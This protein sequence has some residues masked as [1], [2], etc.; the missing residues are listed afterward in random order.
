MP[1]EK[2]MRPQFI[3]GPAKIILYLRLI[4]DVWLHC[5]GLFLRGKVGGPIQYLKLLRNLLL[6]LKVV[7]ANKVVKIGDL[8]KL[9][10]YL[11]AWPSPAFYESIQKFIRPDPGPLTVV[12]SMTKACGYKCPHCYQRNDGGKDLDPEL[13]HKAA[14][15]MQKAGVTMFDIEGGEPLLRFERLL[16]LLEQFDGKR[17]IWVNTTGHTLDKDKAQKM[18]DAGVFGVMI[19]LH[20]PDPASY[21]EF[22]GVPG[23]FEYAREAARL[24]NEVGITVVINHCPSA[25]MLDDGGTV[26]VL[27]TA[28]EWGCSFVQVIHGKSAGAWLGRS[29]DIHLKEQYRKLEELHVSWNSDNE[30]KNKVAAS[31][32]VFEESEAH[33]GCTAGGIDRFYLNAHGEVQPCEFLNISFGNVQTDDFKTIFGRMRSYFRKPGTHWLCCTLA[34]PIHKLMKEKNLTET[35]LT[36]EHTKELLQNWEKGPETKL[37]KD[38]DLYN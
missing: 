5:T 26:K 14:R 20:T 4:L 6:L 13:L 29:E 35:P 31:V 36:W 19:S 12:Y 1:K 27:E 38:M 2:N 33:F 17:E 37:Y 8:Y 9:Q 30:H 22:T 32:Q 25:G 34:E 18:K 24:F 21:E 11:P 10:L 28:T 7:S 16:A 15:D 23:S 3:T